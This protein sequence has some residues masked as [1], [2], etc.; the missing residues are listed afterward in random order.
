MQ[1]GSRGLSV[2]RLSLGQGP[3]GGLA[4]VAGGAPSVVLPTPWPGVCMARKTLT[5]F[6]TEAPRDLPRS[7]TLQ[8]FVP[9]LQSRNSRHISAAIDLP[10]S[11]T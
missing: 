9:T 11:G 6:T 2:G 10:R 4:T 5:G 7:S 8:R 1:W 3:E